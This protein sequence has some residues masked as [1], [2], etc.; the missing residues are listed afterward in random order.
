[1][2]GR[3]GRGRADRRAG[4]RDADGHGGGAL[5]R[6][7]GP[8]SARGWSGIEALSGIPGRVGATPVQNVG[9]YGQ[10]VAQVVTGVRAL[11][12]RT[13]ARRRIGPADCRFE[14][15]HQRLQAAARPLGRPG[16]SRCDCAAGRPGTVRYAE[17]AR[18]L[19]VGVGDEADVRDDPGRRPRAPE[20]ARAWSSTTPI[21]TPGAPGRSSPT[22]SSTRRWRR[23]SPTGCPRYPSAHGVKLSAAWLI[24]QSGVA[25]RPPG[26]GRFRAPGVDEA[27]PCAHEHRQRHRQPTSWSWPATSGHGCSRASA[28]TLQPEVDL[29]G[30]S[31]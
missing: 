4:R 15:P 16:R 17:L 2:H 22:R 12:R 20:A 14:L 30:C 3:E 23:R 24:E 29:V 18:A 13:R 31:L 28:S 19:G 11:D 1:M 6:R 10:E 7:R 8:A 9:A 27:H 26:P 25:P 21:T 5:G